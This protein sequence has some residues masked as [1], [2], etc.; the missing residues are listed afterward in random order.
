M[1]MVTRA[2][3]LYWAGTKGRVRCRER[4]LGSEE[5]GDISQGCPLPT[6]WIYVPKH[7]S[8]TSLG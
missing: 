1:A 3:M 6:C 2:L 8:L 7:T 4:G 5:Q